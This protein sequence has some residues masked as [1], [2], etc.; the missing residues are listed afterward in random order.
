MDCNN[1]GARTRGAPSGLGRRE[2]NEMREARRASK[3]ILLEELYGAREE[4][5]GRQV[6]ERQGELSGRK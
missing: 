2:E 3:L 6:E 4:K 5:D 1:D